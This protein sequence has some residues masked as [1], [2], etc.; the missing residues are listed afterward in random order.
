MVVGP[1]DLRL[2]NRSSRHRC[3]LKVALGATGDDSLFPDT[4]Q[5][6]L[7]LAWNALGL[8]LGLL[9]IG[10]LSVGALMVLPVVLVIFALA[11]WPRPAGTSIV[12]LPSQIA[13]VGG[14]SVV[15]GLLVFSTLLGR[16]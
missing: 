7:L 5:F 9:A 4:R 11:T 10:L 8:G 15:M 12:T 1:L 3:R 13:L 16:M 14:V 6:G 2:R